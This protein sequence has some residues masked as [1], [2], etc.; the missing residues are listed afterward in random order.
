MDRK[1]S[2]HSHVSF[3]LLFFE[4]EIIVQR[5]ILLIVGNTLL[6]LAV[7]WLYFEPQKEIPTVYTPPADTRICLAKDDTFPSSIEHKARM[8]EL[9]I[10][11]ATLYWKLNAPD[12]R[13]HP[14][15]WVRFNYLD[16]GYD[17][18]L[19]LIIDGGGK[20]T[21]IGEDSNTAVGN[22]QKVLDGHYDVALKEFIAVIARDGR[23][24]KIRPFHELDG[25]WYPWGIY[26]QGNSPQMLVDAFAHVVSLFSEGGA[27]AV[28][29]DANL[30]RRDANRLVLG[31]AE[32][33]LPQLRTLIQSVSFST[34]NRGGTSKDHPYERTFQFEFRPA[35]NRA[36]Q[37]IGDTPINVAEVSTAGILS[38]KIPWFRRMLQDIKTD[39]HRT[40]EVT[41]F[42]G[43]GTAT[44]GSTIDWG[45]KPKDH[46]AFRDILEAFRNT[47]QTKHEEE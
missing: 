42:F 27:S 39:F 12:N 4:K 43:E 18:V 34:Y 22:L 11:C 33:Y 19:V 1:T 14:Y 7:I 25:D 9:G 32:A 2:R 44:D 40:N 45:L 16:E 36:Q 37:F 10:D 17:V 38:P 28:T 35:Y 24:I 21:T 47:Q 46:T 15:D 31:D 5:K 13:K 20:T 30:N 8:K 23:P 6:I 41:F 3:L 29:F 26:A